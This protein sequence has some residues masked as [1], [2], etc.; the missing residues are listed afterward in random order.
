KDAIERKL[1]HK[2][3]LFYSNRRPE[4]APYLAELEILR[5]QNPNLTLVATMTEPEKSA[6]VWKGETG[7]I[8]QAMIRKYVSDLERPIYYIAGLSEM[9]AAMKSLLSTLGIDEAN[10]RAEDFSAV[11][12]QI[13]TL[14]PGSWRNYAIPAAI[15]IVVILFIFIHVG[16]TISLYNTA[17]LQNI[18]YLTL[19]FIVVIFAVKIFA[20]V[21]LKHHL[22]QKRK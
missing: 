8:N 5:Q 10:V 1:S 21:K 9:V 18:S 14:M 11:K 7:I 16:A 22:T 4:D 3:V 15:S 17:L 19:G 12:M 20:V 6:Q 2:M 13:M